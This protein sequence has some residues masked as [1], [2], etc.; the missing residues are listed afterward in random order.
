MCSD[1]HLISYLYNF[2]LWRGQN[3]APLAT[4]LK[5]MSIKALKPNLFGFQVMATPLKSGTG[6]ARWIKPEEDEN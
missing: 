3:P 1:F 6:G 4:T 2:T 5:E